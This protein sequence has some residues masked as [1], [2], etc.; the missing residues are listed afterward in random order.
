MEDGDLPWKYSRNYWMQSLLLH[1]LYLHHSDYPSEF[2]MWYPCMWW[3]RERR[4]WAKIQISAT[5]IEQAKITH[6]IPFRLQMLCLLDHTYIAMRCDMLRCSPHGSIL[7]A[8]SIPTLGLVV[9]KELNKFLRL[10]FVPTSCLFVCLDWHY[11]G[12]LGA[13]SSNSKSSNQDFFMMMVVDR[14]NLFHYRW[15]WRWT[16]DV[17]KFRLRPKL[18]TFLQTTAIEIWLKCCLECASKLALK[19]LPG[20]CLDLEFWMILV[21][22][23]SLYVAIA[24]RWALLDS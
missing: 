13:N 7:E 2:R 12:K 4:S 19:E 9:H 23:L 20:A 8:T 14:I 15:D 17:N 6:R 24:V 18:G 5:I 21:S 10:L 16:L 1:H 3:W 11:C 22:C